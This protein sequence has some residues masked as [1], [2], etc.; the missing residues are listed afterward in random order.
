MT[1]RAKEMIGCASYVRCPAD[2]VDIIDKALELIDAHVRG[3]PTD[4][5][6]QDV[7]FE[8]VKGLVRK[9]VLQ[10]YPPEKVLK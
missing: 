2:R 8:K 7:A 5:T 3:L 9:Y 1:W 10:H 4:S 6:E